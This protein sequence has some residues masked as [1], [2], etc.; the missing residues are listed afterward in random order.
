MLGGLEKRGGGRWGWY[1][2]VGVEEGEFAAGEEAAACGVVIGGDVLFELLNELVEI[3][4][5]HC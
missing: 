3:V 4:G 1:E 5:R 2:G